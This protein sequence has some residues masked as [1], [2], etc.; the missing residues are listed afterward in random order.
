[1]LSRLMG[2][3]AVEVLVPTQINHVAGDQWRVQDTGYAGNL[4]VRTS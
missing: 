2:G 4:Q 3:D 1:M